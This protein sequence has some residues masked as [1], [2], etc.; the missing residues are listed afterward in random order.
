MDKVAKY[1]ETNELRLM[2]AYKVL[3]ELLGAM[4]MIN[5]LPS[6]EEFKVIYNEELEAHETKH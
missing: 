4:G 1:E 3:K 2:Q 6:F 5:E